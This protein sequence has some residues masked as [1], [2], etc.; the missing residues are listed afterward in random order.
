MDYPF[1]SEKYK[2]I[3][4]IGNGRLGKSFLAVDNETFGLLVIK[5]IENETVWNIIDKNIVTLLQIDNVDRKS[6][7]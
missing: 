5:I 2:I 7:V 1:I 4:Q 6:V 3:S